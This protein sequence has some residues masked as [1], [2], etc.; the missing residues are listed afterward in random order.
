L[1]KNVGVIDQSSAFDIIEEE[2]LQNDGIL[3]VDKKKKVY[4]DGS[5]GASKI[6][7]KRG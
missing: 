2:K 4:N 5:T 6:N 7:P 3:S 1:H